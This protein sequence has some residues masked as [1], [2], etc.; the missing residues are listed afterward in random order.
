MNLIALKQLRTGE[1]GE[2][3]NSLNYSFIDGY[4][5]YLANSGVYLNR[6]YPVATGVTSENFF[7]DRTFVSTPYIYCDL[8]APE[9]AT[10]FYIANPSNVTRSGVTINYSD[11]LSGSNS[12]GYYINILAGDAKKID[13]VLDNTNTLFNYQFAAETGVYYQDIPFGRSFDTVPYVNC[14]ITSPYNSTG[15]YFI[16]LSNHSTSG[17]R[18]N[19]SAPISGANSTGYKLNVLAGT[20][21][22]VK[23]V[24]STGEQNIDINALTNYLS[25]GEYGLKDTVRTSGNQDISG[26]KSFNNDVVVKG[27]LYVS[28]STIVNEVIDVT[29]TG[30]ISGVTGVFKNVTADNLIYNTSS[31]I[32]SSGIQTG[33]TSQWIDFNKVF[34]VKPFVQTTLEVP[35]N[36][37]GY[38]INFISGLSTSGF[39]SMYSSSLSQ[40]GFFLNVRAEVTV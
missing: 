4:T 2:F 16:G 25:T 31:R 15:F 35:S 17:V 6:R 22:S 5:G 8:V 24:L 19:Y 26:N 28:G 12:T 23:Y 38:C 30:I 11:I 40:T 3:V 20:P 7:F 10:G 14:D 34:A 9:G 33:V 27:N 13:Y 18:V 29:T 37:S 21:S 1:L 36:A 32:F 39:Y